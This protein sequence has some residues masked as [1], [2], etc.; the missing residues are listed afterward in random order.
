MTSLVIDAS[1]AMCWCF[2]DEATE[3]TDQLL[4]DLRVNVAM[5]PAHWFLE[6][7][8]VLVMAERGGR[9]TPADASEFIALLEALNVAVDEEGA[10]HVFGRVFGFARGERLTAYDAAY[11]ELAMR[12]GVPLATKDRELGQAAE[13]LGV[14]VFW[15]T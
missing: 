3:A 1:T 9:I 15:A 14:D 4:R 13:R 11:L 6:I 12:L 8:N 7:T 5:V 10:R 2:E